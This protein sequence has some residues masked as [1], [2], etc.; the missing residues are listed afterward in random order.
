[1]L[2]RHLPRAA[3]LAMLLAAALSGGAASARPAAG[4]PRISWRSHP[5]LPGVRD[6]EALAFDPASGRIAVGDARGVWLVAGEGAPRR[7]LGR[8]PVRDLMFRPG[9]ELLAATDRGLFGIAPEGPV[10]F[11]RLASGK[12]SRV[13]RLAGSGPAVAAGTE[14]GV[15][16]SLDGASFA[17]LSGGLP[18]RPVDALA[19]RPADAGLEL[20]AALE[21]TLQRASVRSGAD[22]VLRVETQNAVIADSPAARGSVDLAA[23][24]AGAELVALSAEHVALRSAG[25]WRSIALELPAGARARRLGRGAGRLWIATDGGIVEARRWEGP[26]RRARPPAGLAPSFAFAGDDERILALGS[27]GLL[28]GSAGAGEAG[29]EGERAVPAAGSLAPGDYLWRL[30]SEP[31][32]QQVHGAALRWLELGPERM[33]SLR[34]GV[35]RRGWLPDVLVRGGA[36]RGHSRRLLED[37]TQSSGVVY[38]LFDREIDRETSYDGGIVLEW[39]LGDLVYHPEALDVAREAREVIELRD[40]VLD[41]VTQLYFERR[42][43]LLALRASAADPAEL[44]RLRLRADELAAGLD[45]WT[46]GFFSRHAPPLAAVASPSPL[47]SAGGTAP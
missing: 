34:R 31:S 20:W 13:R 30:R 3:A 5:A 36:G 11:L 26:W 23:D 6:A 33:A 38:G 37:Q 21:G 47:P 9:G 8:G 22:G 39:S 32:I 4:A 46:G 27:R 25:S 43:T 41:E 1:M 14:D 16:L 44:A 18:S 19:L 45:A 40:E 17:R 29:A 12:A 24:L 42:R 15:F 35:D 28:E 2:R 10:R 7:L